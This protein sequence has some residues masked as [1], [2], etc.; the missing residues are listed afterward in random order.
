MGW[1]AGVQCSAY[2]RL[3]G[4]REHGLWVGT[5]R[6]VERERRGA[7]PAAASTG[8]AEGVPGRRQGALRARVRSP[9]PRGGAPSRAWALVVPLRERS[10]EASATGWSKTMPPVTLSCACVG[11]PVGTGHAGAGEV[12]GSARSG[13]R[14][15]KEG[16]CGS[17][18]AR[19]RSGSRAGW[20]G[21]PGGHRARHRAG[22]R[23]DGRLGGSFGRPTWPTA[24]T[25]QCPHG[26]T[27]RKHLR[28]ANP[29]VRLSVE[30]SGAI[31]SGTTPSHNHQ[32]EGTTKA[33]CRRQ[34][35][36]RDR[37]S[38]SIEVAPTGSSLPWPSVVPVNEAL[39]A[40]SRLS[41]AQG[42]TP[43]PSPSPSPTAQPG[44]LVDGQ[45]DPRSPLDAAVHPA[46]AGAVPS[47][48]EG[49]D[50]AGPVEG[51]SAEAWC[52]RPGGG[53]SRSSLG[54]AGCPQTCVRRRHGQRDGRTRSQAA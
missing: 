45:G 49:L 15:G 14:D 29:P 30:R 36:A 34:S 3:T 42:A 7:R 11:V 40:P 23:T 18:A 10:R 53:S 26:R 1:F 32:G 51:R 5:S 2:A 28:P 27:S 25:P 33:Q 22:N 37:A 8:D 52:G 20:S 31:R 46:S 17:S 6:H 21:G 39:L 38:R 41:S 24:P 13:L 50:E 12:E 16:H 19:G 44:D 47:V 9:R 4:P 35:R 43:S 54:F 48:R